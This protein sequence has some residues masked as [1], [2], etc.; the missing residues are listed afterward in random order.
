[1]TKLGIVTG[2]R[3]EARLLRAGSDGDPALIATSPGTAARGAAARLVDG[4]AEA[5]LSFGLAGGLDPRL[6]PGTLIVAEAIVGPSRGHVATDPPWRRRAVAALKGEAVVGMIAARDRPCVTVAD[7]AALFAATRALAV[8]MESRAIADVAAAHGLPFLAIRAI[9]D[10]ATRRV[11]DSALAAAG[12]D[13]SL[14]LGPLL[15][16]VF[17]APKDLPV[18]CVLARDYRAAMGA[19][20]RAAAKAAPA[21]AFR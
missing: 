1:V 8:D 12:A 16:S 19:L 13:G 14:H 3:A 5:L 15:R 10:P 20:R 4:G 21:F 7:K 9:A 11:P 17:G 18:L 6:A 2:L